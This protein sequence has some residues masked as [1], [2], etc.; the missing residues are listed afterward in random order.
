MT[1]DQALQ[2][3][4]NTGIVSIIRAESGEVQY[5][6]D[7]N[8]LILVPYRGTFELRDPEAPEDFKKTRTSLSFES[9]SILRPRLP[10]SG[11]SSLT[12]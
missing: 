8:H 1:R 4:L 5:N 9:T 10:P 2:K 7:E 11:L 6:Q 12:V 3:V